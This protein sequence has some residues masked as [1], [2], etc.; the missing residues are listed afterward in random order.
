MR[1]AARQR[2]KKVEEGEVGARGDILG[3][4]TGLSGI[5]TSISSWEGDQILFVFLAMIEK[6]R[7]F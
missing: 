2:K 7:A 3:L 5:K 4:P 6:D 1:L